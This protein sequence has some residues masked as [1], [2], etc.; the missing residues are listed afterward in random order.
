MLRYCAS[1]GRMSPLVGTKERIQYGHEFKKHSDIAVAIAPNDMLMHHMYGRWC[2]EVA[3][4]TWMEKKLAATFFGAP[5]ESSYEEAM[6]ALMKADQL[7]HQ[8][9]S[10]QLWISKV[11]IAQKKYSEAIK[12]IDEGL[13]LPVV[14]EEDAVCHEELLDLQKKYSKY[15]Q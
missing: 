10:N 14:S 12:W 15:R 11:L 5:P 1:V 2:Y 4:L 9:I 7:K 13:Q 6:A 3:G 8:W